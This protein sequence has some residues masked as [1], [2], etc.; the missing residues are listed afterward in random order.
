M[1]FTGWPLGYGQFILQ[2]QLAQTGRREHESKHPKY[3]AIGSSWTLVPSLITVAASR[4][5]S[6]AFRICRGFSQNAGILQEGFGLLRSS[7]G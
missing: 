5:N 3:Q 6:C 4:G 7:F 2:T 1:R